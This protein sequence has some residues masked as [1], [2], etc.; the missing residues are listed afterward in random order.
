MT[1]S[2]AI[3]VTFFGF[4]PLYL[5][6]AELLMITVCFVMVVAIAYAVYRLLGFP[7]PKQQPVSEG[8]QTAPRSEKPTQAHQ[9][10]GAGPQRGCLGIGLA[11]LL[12]LAVAEVVVMTV[13][14]RF[15]HRTG[16]TPSWDNL[17]AGHIALVASAFGLLMPLMV[18]VGFIFAICWVYRLVVVG[19]KV[20]RKVEKW[21]D[22]D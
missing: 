20:L 22:E 18:A 15:M 13:L 2:I 14:I 6:W 1:T 3:L 11:I 12:F 10:S 7:S 21:S 19:A 8:E 5:T 17:L 16:E 4:N 9:P